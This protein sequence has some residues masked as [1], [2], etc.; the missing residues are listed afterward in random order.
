[1]KKNFNLTV[2]LPTL[3]ESKTIKK[4]IENIN[5]NL[6]KK[7]FYQILVSDNCSDDNT[8]KIVKKI[9]NV[10]VI[11]IKSRGYG[12]NLKSAIKEINSKY[13]IF[14]DADGSYDPSHIFPMY[15]KIRK[16]NLD[17]VYLNRLCQ[18]EKGSMPFLNKYFGTP[19]LTFFI[20]FLHGKKNWMRGGSERERNFDDRIKDCNS[21]M[22]IFKT[23]KIKKIDFISTGMEFAS[24][25]FIE[26]IRNNLK[27]KDYVGLFRKDLR[28]RQPH[29]RPWK[30][31]WRHLHLILSSAPVKVLN[32]LFILILINYSLS[33][34]LILFEI[35]INVLK[36]YAIVLL[37]V[38]NIFFQIECISISNFKQKYKLHND[39]NNLNYVLNLQKKNFFIFSSVVF[40]LFFI[41]LIFE[42]LTQYFLSNNYFFT[43]DLA[44]KLII[45]ANL[46]AFMI[47]FEMSLDKNKLK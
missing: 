33:F 39:D 7:I 34:F 1:M 27:F 9:R 23:S 25:F 11:N 5:I 15:E 45:F 10:K 40:F 3:N 32:F 26:A 38:L 24:E 29:L 16:E 47:N 42:S 46:S 20:N 6:E 30:D 37:I 44:L 36:Y 18:Q 19:I 13:A 14:F 2:I 21:G 28:S 41:F 4:I 43:A 31:G 22:R 12:Q 35:N 17:L 8:V